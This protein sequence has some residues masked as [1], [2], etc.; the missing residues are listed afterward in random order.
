MFMYELDEI[1]RRELRRRDPRERRR[2]IP[3]DGASQLDTGYIGRIGVGPGA[4]EGEPETGPVK[5]A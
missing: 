2:L 1:E 4:I 3:T 5:L